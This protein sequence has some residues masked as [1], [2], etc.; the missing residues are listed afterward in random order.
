MRSQIPAEEEFLAWLEHPVTQ[1]FQHLLKI[2]Q[3]SLKDQ[4]AAGNFQSE[5]V[6]S[7]AFMNAVALGQSRILDRITELDYEQFAGGLEDEE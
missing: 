6:E 7:T 5:D 4:W 2:W 1:S 3:D